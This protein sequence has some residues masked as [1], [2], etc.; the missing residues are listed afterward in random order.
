MSSYDD[1][2]LSDC[3]LFGLRFKA[4]HAE[5]RAIWLKLSISD[6]SREWGIARNLIALVQA[7][8]PM[9]VHDGLAERMENADKAMTKLASRLIEEM[10][11][12]RE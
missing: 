10:L 6:A 12:H 7:P 2:E 9:P 5:Q 1:G 11:R 8:V 4:T 3:E